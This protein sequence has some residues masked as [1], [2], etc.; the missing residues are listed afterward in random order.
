MARDCFRNTK[1][2]DLHAGISASSEV[3]DYSDVNVVAL[4]SMMCRFG[5]PLGDFRRASCEEQI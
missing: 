5:G 4:A 1:I 2:E 3:G